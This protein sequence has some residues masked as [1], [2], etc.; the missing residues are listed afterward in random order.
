MIRFAVLVL[1]CVLALVCSVSHCLSAEKP[2]VPAVASAVNQPAASTEPARCPGGNCLPKQPEQQQPPASEPPKFDMPSEPTSIVPEVPTGLKVAVL[3][4]SAVI[5]GGA[6][7][8]N[9]WR[10]TYKK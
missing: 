6:G 9:Q 3:I 8:V 1:F 4:A 5:G 2:A 7:V 10:A